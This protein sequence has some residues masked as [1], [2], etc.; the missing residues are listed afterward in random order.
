MFVTIILFALILG[1]LIFVHELGHFITARRNGVTAHEFGFGFPP[2]AIGTVKDPQT[3][4]WRMVFGNQEYY[5]SSTLYSF[6]VIPLGGFV[7]I[8]GENPVSPEDVK[9]IDKMS[10]ADKEYVQMSMAPDSFAV[11]SKWVRCK[12]LA[13]GVTMNFLLAWVLISIVL[14]IGAPEPKDEF[15]DPAQIV[16]TIGVQITAVE[17]GSPA[18]QMGI[19]VGDTVQE[20]CVQGECTTITEVEQLRDIILANMGQEIEVHL[21]RGDEEIVVSGVPRT[22]LAE[23]QG[24]LGVSMMETVIVQYPWYEAIWE[25][26]MR[27]INM[28]VMIVVAF[29]TMIYTFFTGGQMSAEVAGPVGIAMMTQQMR[30]L[31][32]IY[33]LQFVAILSV[34][35][36]IINLLPIPALDGGRILFLGFEAIMGRPVNQRVE[37][38]LH[39]TFFIALLVLM[40]V[41]TVR[42]VLKLF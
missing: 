6:N 22:E 38:I 16:S 35:L 23:D 18:E 40:A 5:G 42:D 29:G 19:K 32:I 37:G 13:A 11:Q 31:G 24:A 33:V 36:G 30:D 14:M 12:I 41:I 28:I 17:P 9:E 4:K 1:V 39:S 21:T 25:G 15:V 8:K 34:N 3:G 10:A 2:R 20:V 7:R 26:L 27:V